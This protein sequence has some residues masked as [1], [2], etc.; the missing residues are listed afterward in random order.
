MNFY[1]RR[2]LALVISLCLVLSAAAAFMPGAVK[3]VLAALTVILVPI[4]MTAVRRRMGFSPSVTP[5]VF[6]A[7]VLAVL[8]LASSFLYYNVHGTRHMA[9][10][11]GSIR[12][13]VVEVR[14]ET[15][16]SAVYAVRL[17]RVDGK[18]YFGKGIMRCEYALSLGLGDVI[19][20]DADF[21]PLAD[22]FNYSGASD[23]SALSDG[24]VF[25]C[26]PMDNV[27]TV[28]KSKSPEIALSELRSYLCAVMGT[29]LDRDVGAMANALFLGVRDGLGTVR[30]DFSRLGIT[31]LL[32]LSGLHIAVIGSALEKLMKMLRIG[33]NLRCVLLTLFLTFYV[34]VTGFLLSAVRAALMLFISYFAQAV[35][36]KDERVTTLFIAVMLIVLISPGAVLDVSLQLSFFATLGVLL[37]TDSVT[38]RLENVSQLGKAGRRMVKFF[39]A[40]AASVGA[41]MFVMPLQWLY[42]GE[43]SLMAVPATLLLSWVCEGMLVLY[44]PYLICALLRLHRIC[45]LLAYVITLLYRLCEFVAEHLAQMTSPVSLKYPFAA[46]L[47]I[48]CVAVIIVMMV[49][50]VKSWIW[51]LIPVT[52]SVSLFFWG[53]WLTERLNSDRITVDYMNTGYHDMLLTVSGRQSVAIDFTYGS[54]TAMYKLREAM[55]EEYL[56]ELDT[57]VLTDISVRHINAVRS[58]LQSRVVRTVLVPGASEQSELYLIQRLAE[59]A[60][61]YGTEV[62]LYPR[63]DETVLY[64]DDM[65]IRLPKYTLIKRSKRQLAAASFKRGDRVLSYLGCSSWENE[66]VADLAKDA[67]FLIIGANGPLLKNAPDTVLSEKTETVFF[68]NEDT[69]STLGPWL[70]GFDGRVRVGNR[71]R[72][73]W[74]GT[75]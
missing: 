36:R 7:A 48:L 44:L 47:M 69:L 30:R 46:P 50:N 68:A 3:L 13:T 75:D 41:S 11:K 31:H 51:S 28:G 66:Y 25:V 62:S 33:K 29:H 37:M 56:T 1:R 8:C 9:L 53:V 59:T 21:V 71:L 19:E 58:M 65:E 6:T 72:I 12:A 26:E 22:Y 64:L 67:Y 57:L 74:D 15:D 60:R 18:R 43:M 55:A 20:V 49:R 38:K 52:L 16:Y 27:N 40:I 23:I 73:V 70:D 34:A 14:S 32:A 63:S 10:E 2:P 24:Y 17:S 42:F 61:E 54:G 5:Y 4:V 39:S 45:D 35:G